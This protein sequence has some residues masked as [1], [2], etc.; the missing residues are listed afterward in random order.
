MLTSKIAT[1]SSSP[2]APAGGRYNLHIGAWNDP[3]RIFLPGFPTVW[4]AWAFAVCNGLGDPLPGNN[5][6]STLRPP[7]I[8]EQ[9][10]MF[11]TDPQEKPHFPE[12]W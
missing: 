1:I 2:M 11:P 4:D 8:I 12:W 10:G 9:V 5:R 6:K 7:E 3:D